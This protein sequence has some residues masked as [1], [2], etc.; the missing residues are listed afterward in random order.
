MD[1]LSGEARYAEPLQFFRNLGNRT[2]EDSSNSAGLNDLR[3]QSCRGAAFG[4]L[5]NDGN[6][7]VVVFNANGPPSLFINETQNA[8]HRVLFRLVGTKSNRAAIGARV[9]VTTAKMIQIDEVRGGVS[10]NSTNDTRFH[11]DSAQMPL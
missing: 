4:D 2:F 11:S 8:N 6:L 9:V 10:Y 7:D 1:A 5:N 3:L